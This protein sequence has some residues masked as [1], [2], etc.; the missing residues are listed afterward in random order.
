[1]ILISE[2]LVY[3]QLK[4]IVFQ[5]KEASVCGCRLQKADKNH[6]VP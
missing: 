1:M 2:K 3:N 4:A 5:K 6:V